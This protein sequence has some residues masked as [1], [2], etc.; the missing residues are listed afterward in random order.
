MRFSSPRKKKQ[1]I[2]F[3]PERRPRRLSH[4]Q[5]S[6]FK[7]PCCSSNMPRLIAETLI[8]TAR[9]SF[10]HI[11]ICFALCVCV[12]EKESLCQK[13]FIIILLFLLL[14]LNVREEEAKMQEHSRF[15]RKRAMERKIFED[16]CGRFVVAA[17]DR[18]DYGD[19]LRRLDC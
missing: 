5:K 7:P 19:I 4:Q 14:M 16:E 18:D 8:M 17:L 10:F 11:A 6:S 13:Q 3:K 15:S 9:L 1:K 12:Q 2:F